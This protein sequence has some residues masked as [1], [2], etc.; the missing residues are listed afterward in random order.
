MLLT[1]LSQLSTAVLIIPDGEKRVMTQVVNNGTATTDS[2]LGEDVVGGGLSSA[3]RTHPTAKK[4]DW[5]YLINRTTNASGESDPHTTGQVYFVDH[6]S[7]HIERDNGG[8][9]DNLINGLVQF[10]SGPE[11][12]KITMGPFLWCWLAF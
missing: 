2:V 4:G 10:L 3:R 7:Q 8:Y 11:W 5:G 1:S 12:L 9:R 6:A